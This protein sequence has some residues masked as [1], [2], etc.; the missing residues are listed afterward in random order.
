M[1]K[2]KKVLFL[3]GTYLNKPSAN[4]ICGKVVAKEFIKNGY[5]VHCVCYDDNNEYK[6]LIEDQIHIHTVKMSFRNR[7]RKKYE[8]TNKKIYLLLS[9]F[10]TFINYINYPVL[11]YILARRYYNKTTELHKKNT[12]D[13]VVAVFNPIESLYS[14]NLLKKFDTKIFNVMYT[15]DTLTNVYIKKNIINGYKYI[16]NSFY[17]RKI[18]KY[19]DLIINMICH[20][21]HYTKKYYDKYNRKMIFSDIPLL[22]DIK[23]QN[24]IDGG[25]LEEKNENFVYT[26]IVDYE[27]RNPKYVCDFFTNINKFNNKVCMNFFSNGDCEDII[28]NYEKETNGVIKSHGFISHKYIPFVINNA[29]VLVSLEAKN[30]EMISA[31]IFEYMSYNKK[32][33]HFYSNDSDVLL[34]YFK[35]YNN[36][37]LINENDDLNYN[38]EKTLEFMKSKTNKN[39]DLK[40]IFKENTPKYTFD[41]IQKEY[42]KFLKNRRKYEEK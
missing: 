26:G 12:F 7:L 33:I 5:E 21:K 13:I 20:E 18:Y 19:S 23:E 2:S 11:N 8:K 41:L 15:L 14:A 22:S 16:K 38:I 37:L 3:M 6:D 10:I 25:Y 39:N 30:S 35:K 27:R 4:G 40:Q 17:E 42:L 31:K 1:K 28:K 36:V 24:L 32:I 34:K 29:D 9:R